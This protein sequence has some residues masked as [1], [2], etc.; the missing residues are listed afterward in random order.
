[1]TH[2]AISMLVF[3]IYMG[4]EAAI[5][6]IIP[7]FLLTLFGMPPTAEI[8]IRAIGIALAV[9]SYYYIRSAFDNNVAFFRWTTQ[10]R[11]LQFLLFC[12]LVLMY[13]APGI[14]ILLAGFETLSGVWTF[15][16]LRT[17]EK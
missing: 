10:G 14:L 5:L 7:N 17:S 16:A 12:G 8:W 6:L 9:L 4:G 1:M 3:G 11:V 2:A 15:F 13:D